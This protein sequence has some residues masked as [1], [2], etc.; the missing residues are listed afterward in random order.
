MLVTLFAVPAPGQCVKGEPKFL[1]TV[2]TNM[3]KASLT[4]LAASL[5][6]TLALDG[7]IDI[8]VKISD[9]Q[10]A[11]DDKIKY[12]EMK[13]GHVVLEKYRVGADFSLANHD[14]VDSDVI[15]ISANYTHSR[16]I[17]ADFLSHVR[18]INRSA[19]IVVGGTDAT[20]D[21]EYYLKIGADVVVR[22]EGEL[23]FHQLV[24]A[25]WEGRDFE[26]IPNIHYFDGETRIVRTNRSTFLNRQSSFDVENLPVPALD[27]VNLSK[28]D[29][30]GEGK[31]PYHFIRGP[32]ISVETSRGCAQACSF[33]ATPIAKGR[34]R[35]MSSKAIE[36]HFKVF[37]DAGVRTLL[38]QEDNVLSRIHRG[39]NGDFVFPE[40]RQATIEMFTIA[41]EMGFSWEFTNR[42]EFGQFE[43]DGKIDVELINV[44]FRHDIGKGRARGCYRATM[45]LE[46]L[47]DDSSRLFR[48]LKPLGIIRNIC[49]AVVATGVPALSFN[50]IIGRPQDDEKILALSFERCLQIKEACHRINAQMDVYFNVYVL[51]LLP[52]TVDFRRFRHILAFDIEKDPE[53]ITFYLGSLQTQHF[54]PLEITQARGTMAQLLNGPSLI[55]NYDENYFLTSSRF[56]RLFEGCY[57]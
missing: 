3:H 38:F 55:G 31:P 44:L 35:F 7:L 16:L 51:S 43:H 17:V 34:F 46:N 41:Y 29:D 21:A 15:G 36:R 5:R 57:V 1:G 19:L 26:D 54:S 30:T 14:I 56:Q 18:H 45:P 53:V 11:G 10:T 42:L 32:F 13:L 25:R 9:L 52:G 27:L 20:G 8:H 28:Y 49:E 4:A 47:S 6:N 2:R 39:K 50:L 12:A 22:G 24:K 37:W 40:G 48:K 33:C 23:T